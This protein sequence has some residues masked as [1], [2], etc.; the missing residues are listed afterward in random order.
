MK[1][2]QLVVPGPHQ[3]RV[4]EVEISEQGPTQVRVR[5]E[6]SLVSDG[7]APGLAAWLLPEELPG[8][9]AVFARMAKTAITAAARSSVTMG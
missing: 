1:G 7:T 9:Q 8:E 5:T 2:I 6:G 3:V 4:E